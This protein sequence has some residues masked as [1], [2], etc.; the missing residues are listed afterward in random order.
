ML[1]AGLL[2]RAILVSF[3][4]FVASSFFGAMV[5]GYGWA[6][7]CMDACFLFWAVYLIYF[8]ERFLAFIYTM[9]FSAIAFLSIFTSLFIY[10]LC[11]EWCSQESLAAPVMGLATVLLFAI[12][13]A[14]AHFSKVRAQIFEFKESKVKI[15][16]GNGGQSRMGL[17]TI[18]GSVSALFAKFISEIISAKFTIAFA[19]VFFLVCGVC[20]ISRLRNVMAN[21][22]MLYL[23]EQ[24][25]GV[26]Y[27][28]MEVESMRE[29]R[30]KWWACRIFNWVYK[31]GIGNFK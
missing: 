12:L 10:F 28:F 5:L 4:S 30:K 22:R 17:M 11:I 8:N 31:W 20:I 2:R 6:F 16:Q 19:S 25:T 23:K 27:T 18:I 7:F 3:F 15:L 13:L 26:I 14:L 21:L 24:A 29:A 1:D 9:I